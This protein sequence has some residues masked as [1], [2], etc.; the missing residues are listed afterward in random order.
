MYGRHFFLQALTCMNVA[1]SARLA[2]HKSFSFF[3]FSFLALITF[4]NYCF[5]ASTDYWLIDWWLTPQ[6]HCGHECKTSNFATSR[7][8]SAR[9][10]HDTQRPLL[11]VS[12]GR[13][14]V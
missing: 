12:R 6:S 9:K 8:F 10:N 14:R 3:F 1:K 4:F 13:W 5:T 7:L 11:N 2:V